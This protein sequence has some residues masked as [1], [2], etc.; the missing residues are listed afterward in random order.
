M[1]LTKVRRKQNSV[2][3][4]MRIVGLVTSAILCFIFVCMVV[5]GLIFL[6][7]LGTAGVEAVRY[8]EYIVA[9]LS[10]FQATSKFAILESQES[11]S[12]KRVFE[13]LNDFKQNL[14]AQGKW[15]SDASITRLLL[16]GTEDPKI[17]FSVH[18]ALDVVDDHD[19]LPI[20]MG[21]HFWHLV[22]QGTVHT[23]VTIVAMRIMCCGCTIGYSQKEK[24]SDMG[25]D[26]S[27]T[28]HSANDSFE[29]QTDCC[30]CIVE[31]H[32]VVVLDLVGC[33]H[34]VRWLVSMAGGCW[35]CFTSGSL[36]LGC[37]NAMTTRVQTL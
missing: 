29:N 21:G 25:D 28:P 10:G 3:D 2:D 32:R 34:R 23:V 26:A 4:G 22:Q 19:V 14:S 1:G 15:M 6:R 12:A 35:S 8:T 31:L 11:G 17:S 5:L 37:E 9:I 24:S 20:R 7:L 18:D 33:T 16:A 13:V 27:G 36:S 30:I